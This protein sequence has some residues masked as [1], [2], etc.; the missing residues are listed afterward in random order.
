MTESTVVTGRLVQI[1]VQRAL[2][3]GNSQTAPY[4]Q[5]AYSAYVQGYFYIQ[6]T[7]DFISHVGSGHMPS[8]MYQAKES[9]NVGQFDSKNVG[10]LE[11]VPDVIKY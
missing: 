9:R 7:L 5:A 3:S 1:E 4:R 8:K 11:F 6:H 2:H 10:C